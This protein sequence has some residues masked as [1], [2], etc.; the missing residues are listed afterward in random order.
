MLLCGICEKPATHI[1]VNYRHSIVGYGEVFCE[2]HAFIDD[3]EQCPCC[4]D[5]IIE[6]T[7]SEG[8][9]VNLLPTYPEGAL[10]D[11]ECCSEHP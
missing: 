11:E 1:L 2:Q 8:D 5:Y 9:R 4:Y 7:P 3:R 6:F 10:D